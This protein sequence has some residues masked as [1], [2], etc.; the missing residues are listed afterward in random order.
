MST[1]HVSHVRGRTSYP[2]RMK[3]D[4]KEKTPLN[5]GQRFRE[6]LKAK[7]LKLS[8]IARDMDLAESTLRSWTNGSRDINL[9]DFLKLCQA[10]GLDPAVILFADQVDAKFLAIG[11]AWSKADEN[12]R[13]VLW[14]AA[15]GILAQHEQ[16]KRGTG[17][18]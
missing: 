11:V 3:K 5:W 10:A 1:H 15:Q 12:Q 16:Q 6:L 4:K 17:T 13:G 18:S 8:Q 7:S 2:A 14:T 9:S